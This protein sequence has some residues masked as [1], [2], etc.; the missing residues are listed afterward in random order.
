M[1]NKC[2]NNGNNLPK[3]LQK[4]ASYDEVKWILNTNPT[5]TQIP[6]KNGSLP[7]HV[8]CCYRASPNVIRMILESYPKAAQIKNNFGDLP[9]HLA[10][11]SRSSTNVIKLLYEVYPRAVEVQNG[12]GNLPLHT[13]VGTKACTTILRNLLEAFPLALHVQNKR[14]KTPLDIAASRG[15]FC[16]LFQLSKYEPSEKSNDG[17]LTSYVPEHSIEEY[18]DDMMQRS[19]KEKHEKTVLEIQS[20]R[21]EMEDIRSSIDTMRHDITSDMEQMLYSFLQEIQNNHPNS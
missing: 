12:E 2:S 11:R 19:M 13:A 16:Y 8:A 21:A 3:A 17:T 9:L 15:I 4:Q 20:L 18:R 10:L 5:C 7:L 14:G 1:G 6:N